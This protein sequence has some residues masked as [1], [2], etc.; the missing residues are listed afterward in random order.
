VSTPA[1]R[2]ILLRNPF[3]ALVGMV[4]S[5]FSRSFRLVCGLQTTTKMKGSPTTVALF[6]LGERIWCVLC[7]YIGSDSEC[8]CVKPLVVDYLEL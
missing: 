2:S 6:L 5:L 7:A 8:E 4:S 1:N 3:V